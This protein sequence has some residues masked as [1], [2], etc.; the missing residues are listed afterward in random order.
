MAPIYTI[1]YERSALEDFLATLT[2]AGVQTLVDIRERPHSR[3]T[4]FS[5]GN[6]QAAVEAAGMHYH[7]ERPLGAPPHIR[8]AVQETGDYDTFFRRYREHL[9]QQEDALQKLTGGLAQPLALL[10]YEADPAQCHRSAVAER[11]SGL[12]GAGIEH[13]R[14]KPHPTGPQQPLDL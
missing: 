14:V 13:L 6:L 9:A 5:K 10:C 8:H 2:D 3:R 1:G 4:E 11:V 12:T 7:H